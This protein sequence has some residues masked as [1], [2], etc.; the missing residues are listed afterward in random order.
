MRQHGCTYNAVAIVLLP[1]HPRL[2]LEKDGPSVLIGARQ[3]PI[4]LGDTPERGDISLRQ[5]TVNGH[6]QE[7]L[8]LAK[9]LLAHLPVGY[10]AL[11]RFLC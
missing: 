6:G 3:D 11:C 5:S 4:V 9:D 1:V 2:V 8:F 7:S 10:E